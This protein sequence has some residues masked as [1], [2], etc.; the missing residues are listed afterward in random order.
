MRPLAHIKAVGIKAYRVTSGKE[1]ATKPQPNTNPNHKPLGLKSLVAAKY[2][3]TI[4]EASSGAPGC[5]AS[6]SEC[7]ICILA[8]VTS[9]SKPKTL[10]QPQTPRL[11]P[12]SPGAKPQTAIH[13]TQCPDAKPQTAIHK[14]QCPDAKPQTASHK[15]QS[16]GPKPQTALHIL[17]TLF[18]VNFPL[19]SSLA[20]FNFYVIFTP[21]A[22]QK[23]PSTLRS[24]S[25]TVHR[26]FW[27]L[28]LH[29]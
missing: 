1:P 6:A 16:P 17:I 5:S 2:S 26:V 14:P 19:K 15:P 25:Q 21:S 18:P 13:K 28:V 4:F 23:T 8:Q 24:Q 22:A 27:L 12:Q 20:L 10:R 29:F 7:I 9:N 11:K 3:G